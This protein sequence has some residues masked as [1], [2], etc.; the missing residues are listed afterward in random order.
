MR[1]KRLM[2]RLGCSQK[3]SV[4]QKADSYNELQVIQKQ[5]GTYPESGFAEGLSTLFPR[6]QHFPELLLEAADR[7]RKRQRSFFG[8]FDSA[9]YLPMGNVGPHIL[10]R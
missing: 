10:A 3:T 2:R 9:Q 8:T 4:R 6:Q 1:E 7:G 5:A